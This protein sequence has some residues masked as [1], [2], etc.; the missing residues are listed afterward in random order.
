MRIATL[1]ALSTLSLAI[2]APAAAQ[3]AMM[4]DGMKSGAMM[5]MSAADTRRMKA[6]NAMTHAKMMKNARCA[7]MMK[8]HPSMMKHDAMM[9]KSH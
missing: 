4:N 2:V 8:M 3:D 7:K 6:C 9:M 5:K 1:L